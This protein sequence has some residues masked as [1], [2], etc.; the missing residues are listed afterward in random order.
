MHITRNLILCTAGVLT[1]CFAGIAAAQQPTIVTCESNNYRNQEC[2]VPP[3]P[4]T[5]I[6]QLSS[7]PGDCIEGRTWGHNRN[8]IWVSNGC[9]AEF[10]V[11][12]SGGYR[13][14]PGPG[15]GPGQT[16]LCESIGYN[17]QEC[18]VPYGPVYM[19]R[20]LSSPPGDCIE[21]RTWGYNGNVIWVNG[22]CRAEFRAGY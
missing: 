14:Q 9:R 21:G 1:A 12:Y 2:G 13:P 8:V 19:S 10:Q 20:Q 18:S 17:P 11:G 7:P 22:G 15:P 4:V 16:V 6:R 5:L 3:G